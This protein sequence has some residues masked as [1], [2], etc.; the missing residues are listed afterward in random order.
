[1]NS[2]PNQ[3][4]QKPVGEEGKKI[5]D[6]KRTTTPFMTKYER[7]RGL[8]AKKSGKKKGNDEDDI[9]AKMSAFRGKLQG[10]LVG[11]DPDPKPSIQLNYDEAPQESSVE[12]DDDTGFMS[13]VLHFP[14]DDGEETRKA[15]RDYEVIDPR[16]RSARAREEERQRK[17]QIRTRDGGRGSSR[18]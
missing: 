7:A 2:D 15:D 12:V 11:E 10:S 1:M 18:R 9:L 5:P 4:G 13:H 14:K 6:N 17:K 8:K 3:T 16:Q